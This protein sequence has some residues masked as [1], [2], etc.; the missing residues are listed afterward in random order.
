MR[1]HR[2]AQHTS[3]MG[4]PLAVG[5]GDERGRHTR[6]NA[7]GLQEDTKD[8][9][10][11]SDACCE[12]VLWK[13]RR[14]CRAVRENSNLLQQTHLPVHIH[15]YY[16]DPIYRD[17][18]HALT[19]H[20]RI[21]MC[22]RTQTRRLRASAQQPAQIP[23]WFA[24]LMGQARKT[25]HR[26]RGRCSHPLLLDPLVQKQAGPWWYYARFNET[27][28]GGPNSAAAVVDMTGN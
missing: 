18:L 20:A 2:R 7:Q 1:H 8:R 6:R 14:R 4:C 10:E 21:R 5:A 13:A 11:D 25:R 28:R 17:M 19:R 15:I 12:G 9:V 26:I 22:I 27:R 3:Q 24:G 16:Q 23:P